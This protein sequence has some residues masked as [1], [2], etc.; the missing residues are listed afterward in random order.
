MC[1]SVPSH[2][3]GGFRKPGSFELEF[4][5]KLIDLLQVALR[6]LDTDRTEVFFQAL[7]LSRAGIGTIHGF[8]ANSQ[9]SAT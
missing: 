3:E 9:A 5:G 1:Y 8:C 2:I 6:K 7:Q 4:G